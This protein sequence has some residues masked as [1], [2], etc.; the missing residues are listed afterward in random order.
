[1]IAIL[2]LLILLVLLFGSGAVLTGLGFGAAIF[3][4]LGIIG[5]LGRALF[6]DWDEIE[7]RRA[8]AGSDA[9][10]RRSQ[11]YFVPPEAAGSDES[12]RRAEELRAVLEASRGQPPAKQRAADKRAAALKEEEALLHWYEFA[13]GGAKVNAV[14]KD[15]AQTLLRSHRA[16]ALLRLYKRKYRLNLWNQWAL[17]ALWK[18]IADAGDLAP[19]NNGTPHGTIVVGIELWHHCFMDLAKRKKLTFSYAQQKF[20]DG[21]RRLEQLGVIG[22]RNNIA[23]LNDVLNSAPSNHLTWASLG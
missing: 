6:G 4:I 2:L 19:D 9:R 13:T 1:M 21:Q 10:A 17:E 5:L 8:Q 11:K 14:D 7:A 16:K 18:A 12:E 3:V 23:W 15:L 20:Q 22:V